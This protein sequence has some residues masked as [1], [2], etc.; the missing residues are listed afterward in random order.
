MIMPEDAET[1]AGS[2]G[3]NHLEIAQ[4]LT[5]IKH[6]PYISVLPQRLAAK[7]LKLI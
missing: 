4:L 3:P 5:K 1:N 6:L 2:Y 7:Y